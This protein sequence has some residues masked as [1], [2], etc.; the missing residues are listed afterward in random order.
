MMMHGLTNPKSSH[1]VHSWDADTAYNFS[2]LL[3][4]LNLGFFPA[5]AFIFTLLSY[6]DGTLR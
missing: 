2:G 4:Q 5:T 6:S 1:N 3:Q